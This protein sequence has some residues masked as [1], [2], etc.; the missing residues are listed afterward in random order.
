MALDYTLKNIPAD[1]YEMTRRSAKANF[2]TVEQEILSRVQATFDAE[3]AASSKLHQ[4]WV[5]EALRSG[6]AQ[7]LDRSKQR[8]AVRRGLKKARG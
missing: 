4:T 6:P 2:R 3:L 5:D 1:L 8:A 7:P